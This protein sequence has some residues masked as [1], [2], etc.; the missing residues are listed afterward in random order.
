MALFLSFLI[1]LAILYTWFS[2]DTKLHTKKQF[3]SIATDIPVIGEIPFIKDKIELQTVS[4]PSSR[5]ALGES[6]RMISSNFN[7]LLNDLNKNQSNSNVVLITSSVK[8]EG[9][10]L[11]SVN[12]ASILSAKYKNILLVG[13]DLRNQL[14]KYFNIDKNSKGISDYVYGNDIAL[15]DIVKKSKDFDYIISG[16]I[17]PNPIEVLSSKRFKAMISNFS[18]KYD[19]ILIDSAPT[20][21]VSDTFDI[22][23]LVSMSIYVTRSN[24]TDIKLCEYI[25]SLKSENKLPKI[26]VVL[27]G[28]GNSSSYG[29]KYGYQYGYQYGYKYGYNYGYGYGYK[30]DKD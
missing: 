4:A 22:S 30:E 1:P 14:H 9:K 13:A 7:F 26:N 24:F 23:T 25:D 15:E 10:T 2:L 5:S 8:G 11:I 19:F 27:N 6:I 16:P 21:L 12:L 3:T 28:I 29:Y 20:L 17:P 18:K